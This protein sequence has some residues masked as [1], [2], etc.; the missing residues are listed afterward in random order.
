MLDI[1]ELS[2]VADYVVICSADSERQVSALSKQ[3]EDDLQLHKVKPLSIEGLGESKW[4]LMD[5]ND[6]IVHIFLTPVRSYYDLEGL[7]A[8]AEK[9]DTA[10]T[11]RASTG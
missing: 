9:I 3:I 8:D 1:K 2:S 7:W 5:Y 4:V 6:V 11:D 10:G